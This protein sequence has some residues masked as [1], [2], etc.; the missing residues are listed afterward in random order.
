MI[1]RRSTLGRA[2][3]ASGLVAFASGCATFD[4][5][6]NV[7]WT[8][9]EVVNFTDGGLELARTD[10]ERE[11]RTR[12]AAQLLAEPLGR[13][14]AVRLA[15]LNSPAIQTMLADNWAAGADAAQSG[16]I[17][18]PVFAFERLATDDDAEVEIERLFAFGLLDVLTV[19]FKQ[20]IAARRIERSKLQ[21]AAGV[22]D[23]V[24]EVRQAWVEAV[25]AQQTLT[26]VEQVRESAAVTAEMARRM[27]AV[28]NFSRLARVRQQIFYAN[29]TAEL[30]VAR[31]QARAMRERLARLLGLDDTQVGQLVLPEQLPE[32]PE[33][34]IQPAEIAETLNERRLD[35]RMARAELEAA[36]SARGLGRLTTFIDIEAGY[37][38]ATVFT[39]DEGDGGALEPGADVGSESES[40][41]GY[42]LELEI[43]LFDWGGMQRAGLDARSLAAA[44]AYA[45]TLRSVGSSMR[46]SYSAYRTGFDVA[47]HYREEILPLIET[48]SEENVLQYNGMLIGVFELLADSRSAIEAVM[49]AIDAQAQFWS[50]EAALQASMT[51]R[52]M[53]ATVAATGGDGGGGDEE[54]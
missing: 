6:D 13:D 24:T 15:L 1:A 52:P 19:P 53:M 21:L 48:I 14:E 33:R 27:E 41:S 47:R 50:A 46:E 34:P 22:V 9:E 36:G 5:G 42:E 32:L 40:A 44:N 45:G 2:I 28:G 29:A 4:I 26:Y 20:R 49:A 23:R 16:R 31:H 10:A 7:S 30:A 37:R 12:A 54:H 51:G 17:P 39:R 3:A 43:P 38:T 8:N 18:N 11:A 35:V 25:A